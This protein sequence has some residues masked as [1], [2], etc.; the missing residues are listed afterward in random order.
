ME[1]ALRRIV[2]IVAKTVGA[3]DGVGL[4]ESCKTNWTRNRSRAGDRQ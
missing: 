2:V 3:D 4:L 1:D